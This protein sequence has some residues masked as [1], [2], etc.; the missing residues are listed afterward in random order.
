MAQLIFCI[1]HLVNI[2]CRLS[3]AAGFHGMV[4]QGMHQQ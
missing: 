1:V 3:H 4:A 2:R